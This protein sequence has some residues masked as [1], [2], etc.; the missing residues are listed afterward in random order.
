MRNAIKEYIELSGQEKNDL[1][2]TATFVFDTNVCLNLYRYSN[3]TKNLLIESFKWLKTRIWMPYQVASEFCK[4][5]YSV[6][7]EA[8]KR[9]DTIDTE[10]EKL[11]DSWRKELRLESNDTDIE[12]LSEFLKQWIAK[13]RDNNYLTFSATDDEVFSSLLDLFDGKVGKPFSLEER[14]C[15]EQEGEKRYASKMPPGYKDSKK[16]DNRFGDLLI[17]K[18]I[19]RY[20]TSKKVNIVFVTD[21]QKEDWWNTSSGKT[22][23]PKIEL[24]KEFYEETGKMFHMYTMSAFLSLFEKNKGKTIDKAIMD[25]VELVASAMRKKTPFAEFVDQLTNPPQNVDIDI[26]AKKYLGSEEQT[27]ATVEFKPNGV[28][29]KQALEALELLMCSNEQSD[30]LWA[31]QMLE[32]IAESGAKMNSRDRISLLSELSHQASIGLGQGYLN[33]LR[34]KILIR[35]FDKLDATF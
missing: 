19:L 29:G 21:D 31:G 12:E 27:R 18:E 26:D 34:R 14:Q 20:A 6:I 2:N 17:W 22:I 15:I 5:R 4:D 28:M 3:K 32:A 8:N 9:F 35:A 7:D 10:A 16:T 33:E 25:E 13:K 30:V 1:W 11:V 24:R 23:G